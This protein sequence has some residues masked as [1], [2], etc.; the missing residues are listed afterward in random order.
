MRWFWLAVPPV[1]LAVS[2]VVLG[3]LGIW[4]PLS[5]SV[6]LLLAAALLVDAFVLYRRGFLVANQ[7]RTA[8]VLV[9][10]LAVIGFAVALA[11][12]LARPDLLSIGPNWDV[13][14]HLP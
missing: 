3:W 12:L 1:G 10:G 7:E 2:A 6:W 11:P 9:A 4:L 8:T 13:E 5:V 14:I